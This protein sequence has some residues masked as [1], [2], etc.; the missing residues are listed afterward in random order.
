M[1]YVPRYIDGDQAPDYQILQIVP[2]EL[3][4]LQNINEPEIEN[5]IYP[6]DDF[7]LNQDSPSTAKITRETTTTTTTQPPHTQQGDRRRARG[8]LEVPIL[9]PEEARDPKFIYRG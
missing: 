2:T 1:G 6:A 7:D 9:R 3:E 4:D 8:M 5:L